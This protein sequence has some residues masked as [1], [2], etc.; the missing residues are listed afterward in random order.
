M[1]SDRQSNLGSLPTKVAGPSTRGGKPVSMDLRKRPGRVLIDPGSDQAT[2]LDLSL[3][4]SSRVQAATDAALQAS[5]DN[6]QPIETP[7]DLAHS[8]VQTLAKEQ[9]KKRATLEFFSQPGAVPPTQEQPPPPPSPPPS[10][11]QYTPRDPRTPFPARIAVSDSTSGETP[12]PAAERAAPAISREPAFTVVFERSNGDTVEV[13]YDDVLMDK[14]GF[15]TLARDLSSGPSA[16]FRSGSTSEPLQLTITRRK[17][18]HT[19]T[20]L[21]LPTGFRLRHRNWEYAV[22]VIQSSEEDEDRG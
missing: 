15:L 7:A 20:L 2:E 22:F 9:K 12:A 13:C 11:S 18:T 3:L 1:S 21:C 8:V 14:D 16:Q 4:E 19:V 5:S 6:Q 10:P 17:S